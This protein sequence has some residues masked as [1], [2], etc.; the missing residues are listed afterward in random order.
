MTRDEQVAKI[1]RERREREDALLLLLLLLSRRARFRVNSAIR[2]GTDWRR[3]LAAVLLGSEA[4]DQPGGVDM[5]AM[6]MA[7]SHATA[8]RQVGR[9]VDV[10]V[11]AAETREELVRR[12]ES[13]ARAQ[14]ERIRQLLEQAVDA[15]LAESAAADRISADVIAAGG[16][17][18]AAGFV[19]DASSGAE[20]EATAAVTQAYAAGM[21]EGYGSDAVQAVMTGL[22][23]VNPLDER[24][25]SVCRKRTGVTLPLDHPWWFGNWPP[26]H[27]GCRS[28]VL[29]LT[30]AGV[31]FTEV[32]PVFPPPDVGWGQWAGFLSSPILSTP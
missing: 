25:T 18:H 6:V 27:W 4:L 28:I 7:D 30:G 20:T 24:T 21:G 10:D 2:N 3:V 5:L 15:A 1:E 29:P 16:A 11:E 26:L 22:R 31:K 9:L 14:L 19:E 13:R 23:F 32:P 12:Y 17:F 8:V